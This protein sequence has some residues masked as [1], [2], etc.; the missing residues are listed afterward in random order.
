MFEIHFVK[1]CVVNS[2]AHRFCLIFT[3]IYLFNKHLQTI[4][5][6]PNIKGESK[7]ER[8]GNRGKIRIPLYIYKTN[9]K[10]W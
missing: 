9:V 3:T 7:K 1:I 2:S 5:K 8:K 10:R 6:K 4:L